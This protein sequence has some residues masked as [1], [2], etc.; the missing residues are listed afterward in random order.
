M[1]FHQN[2]E[3][4]ITALINL[5]KFSVLFESK[6][7]K[8]FKRKHFSGNSLNREKL[9]KSLKWGKSGLSNLFYKTSK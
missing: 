9:M 4:S 3:F 8:T 5:K 1:K 7:D 6:I 2:H